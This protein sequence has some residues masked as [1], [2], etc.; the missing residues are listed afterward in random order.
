MAKKLVFMYPEGYASGWA[1]V[2]KI[3]Q[4]EKTLS[5]GAEN[6]PVAVMAM[7]AV[8]EGFRALKEPVSVQV[9]TDSFVVTAFREG[10]VQ[11]WVQQGWVRRNGQPVQ[12]VE[13]W[14][15]ILQF[16]EVHEVSWTKPQKQNGMVQKARALAK[17]ESQKRQPE[18]KKVEKVEE[19]KDSPAH[20][21]ELRS[22]QQRIEELSLKGDRK[23][24][25]REAIKAKMA[26][27]AL[28]P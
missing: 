8:L 7:T 18:A 28:R 24:I 26:L 25:Y 20:L 10:W 19:I 5:G 23:E 9:V 16:C 27:K 12:S 3:G 1:T 4:H 6:A 2:L 22:S 13:L 11:K 15:E 21:D 14:K 17:Q